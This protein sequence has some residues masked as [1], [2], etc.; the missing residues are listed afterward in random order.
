MNI[1]ETPNGEGFQRGEGPDPVTIGVPRPPRRRSRRAAPLAAVTA[2]ALAG[3]VG[4]GLAATHSGTVKATDTALVVSSSPTASASSSPTASPSSSPTASPSSSPSGPANGPM[5]HHRW[6]GALPPKAGFASG[7][8]GMVHG[9][10]T[11]PKSGGGYQTVDVQSGT[12]SA[13]SASSVTV[14]SKDGFTATYTV[15]SSTSVD[16]KA[17]GISSVKQG[18]TIFIIAKVSGTTATASNV[19]DMTAVKAGR[20]SLPHG[21]PGAKAGQAPSGFP[22]A[23]HVGWKGMGGPRFFHRGAPQRGSGAPQQNTGAP[24]QSM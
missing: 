6:P 13:V 1:Q 18:D 19:F 23:G 21:F 12:V 5:G 15:T 14:K 16:A 4:V 3:G 8:I 24:Q 22:G 17:A 2:L 11:V 10:L 20:V 9:Q 7:L